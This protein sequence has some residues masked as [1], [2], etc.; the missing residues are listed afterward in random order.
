MRF[1]GTIGSTF[2]AM[3]IS[4]IALIALNELASEFV[5]PPA[6]FSELFDFG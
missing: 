1:T 5:E 6:A 3:V 2:A 4:V